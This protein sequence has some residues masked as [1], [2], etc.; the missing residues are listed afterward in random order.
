[1]HLS[2][3]IL[4]GG[5]NRRYNGVIKATLVV[6]GRPIIERTLELFGSLFDDIV[7][8]TNNREPF[9]S[10][11]KIR[12]VEDIYKGI[13]PLGGLHAALHAVNTDAIFMVA[14]DMPWLSGD[15]I[16]KMI[17]Y[18]QKGGCEVLVPTHNGK[19]ETLHAIYSSALRDRLDNFLGETNRFAIRE[20]LKLAK[21]EY[22]NTE[23][24]DG[25]RNPFLNINRPE[26]FDRIGYDTLKE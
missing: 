10:Y 3:A 2:G 19:E 13:G 23:I 22:F 5:E 4:A 21:V 11:S 20:F 18:F 6:E 1:M 25:G 17:Q 14:S 26:D 15:L 12:M 9:S 16:I 24:T 8:V 7:V